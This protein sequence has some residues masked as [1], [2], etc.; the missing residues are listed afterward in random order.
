[1]VAFSLFTWARFVEEF[2]ATRIG[3]ESVFIKLS[4]V[5]IEVAT[6]AK[7]KEKEVQL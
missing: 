3:Q 7:E 2:E 6:K 1:M 5:V 4:S